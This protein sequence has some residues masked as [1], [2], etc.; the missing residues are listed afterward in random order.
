MR[1]HGASS[2]AARPPSTA[3][4]AAT[5]AGADRLRSSGSVSTASTDASPPRRRAHPSPG[6]RFDGGALRCLLGT[7]TRPAGC[8]LPAAPVEVHSRHGITAEPIHLPLLIID[9]LGVRKLPDTAAEDLLDLIL[10][11]CAK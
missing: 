1:T 11:E 2:A 4:H 3:L 6:S 5:D 7:S 8:R 9:D 10:V